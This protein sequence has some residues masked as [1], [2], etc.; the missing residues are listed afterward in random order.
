MV[1]VKDSTKPGKFTLQYISSIPPQSPELELAYAY[2]DLLDK[3]KYL[4]DNADNDHF[5]NVENIFKSNRFNGDC[6][7]FAS[8]LFAI[9]RAKK[10]KSRICLA[11]NKLKNSGHIWADIELCSNRNF[12]SA[13]RD[14]IKKAFPREITVY[15]EDTLTYLAFI[16]EKDYEHY[17]VTNHIDT[18]G[19][20]TR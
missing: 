15:D 17:I 13:L 5:A 6:E 9:C 2:Y 11:K 20:L 18:L 14:R 12:T 1:E 16:G 19:H 4:N 10:Y 3:W 8:M 7:D